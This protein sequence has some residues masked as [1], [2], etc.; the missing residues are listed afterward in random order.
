[1]ADG[2]QAWVCD[3][4]NLKPRFPLT[5]L[6]GRYKVVFRVKNAPGSKFTGFKTLTLKAGETATV[7]VFN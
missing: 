4:N 6:P 7:N 5:L 1:L 3:L 2:T